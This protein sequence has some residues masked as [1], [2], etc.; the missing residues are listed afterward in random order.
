VKHPSIIAERIIIC[1][2]VFA[3]AVWITWAWSVERCTMG[4]GQCCGNQRHIE[5]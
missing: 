5:D 1:M 4:F 3:Y 2:T